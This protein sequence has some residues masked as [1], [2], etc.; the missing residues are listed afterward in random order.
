MASA[1]EEHELRTYEVSWW[2][3]CVRVLLLNPGMQRSEC[4]QLWAC[5][6]V[7]MTRPVTHLF[8]L[9][10]ALLK[11]QLEENQRRRI[12]VVRHEGV[13]TKVGE[14]TPWNCFSPARQRAPVCCS[15]RA[16]RRQLS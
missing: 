10:Q 16:S 13:T 11:A 5:K 4:L 3:S 8:V 7:A 14:L 9:L 2:L 1:A 12:G 6:M 15:G